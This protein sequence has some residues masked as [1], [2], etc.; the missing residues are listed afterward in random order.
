MVS[1]DSPT[2]RTIAGTPVP[3]GAGDAPSARASVSI[4][5]LRMVVFPQNALA[6]SGENET[7]PTPSARGKQT[8][9]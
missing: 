5:P 4:L 1:H 2:T 3:G 9:L 7:S 6:A 8:N